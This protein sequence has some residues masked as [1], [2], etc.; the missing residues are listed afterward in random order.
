MCG[1]YIHEKKLYYVENAV[2]ILLI[3]DEDLFDDLAVPMDTFDNLA[4]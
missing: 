3:H 4:F 1:N 2:S